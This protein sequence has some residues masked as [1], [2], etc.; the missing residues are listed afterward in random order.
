MSRIRYLH[1]ALAG[2]LLALLLWKTDVT[3]VARALRDTSPLTAATVVALNAPIVVLFWL[4]SRLV[5]ERLGHQLP[6]RVLLPVALLGNVAG[7]L[8]PASAGELLRTTMLKSHAGVTAKDGFA[9]VLYERALSVYLMALGTGI[10]AAFVLLPLP[11][12]SL[13]AVIAALLAA[14][15]IAS[16]PTLLSV[17][18]KRRLARGPAFLRHL[19]ERA[20]DVADRLEWLLRDR[21]LLLTWTTIT[22]LI[23]GLVTAQFW[24][25]SRA[26]SDAVN[27][28]EAWLAFG[29]SQLATIASLLPLGLG[30]A[31]GSIAAILRRAGMT[32]EQ[33]TAVAIL[34]R[35]TI[36]LPLGLA[37]VACYLYLQRVGATDPDPS[38]DAD[39]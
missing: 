23:F 2:G 27:P 20:A 26:L 31:D 19:V 30:A 21:R 34:V 8:T 35:A 32:L 12:A 18:P 37:A 6:A 4:R 1:L 24:L 28:Q 16:G 11:V 5:L 33:G 29:A 15:P 36:T 25:L 9:L 39:T 13:I 3:G 7:S 10:V 22:G 38:I 17:L 14:L